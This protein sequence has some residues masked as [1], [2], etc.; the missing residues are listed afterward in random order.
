M[1]SAKLPLNGEALAYAAKDYIDTAYEQ[2]RDVLEWRHLPRGMM[3]IWE[4]SPMMAA[5]R[6]N[7]PV[8]IAQFPDMS[9]V[10]VTFPGSTAVNRMRE[11]LIAGELI[12]KTDNQQERAHE[13]ATELFTLCMRY[14]R[15]QNLA[16]HI[17]TAVNSHLRILNIETSRERSSLNRSEKPLLSSTDSASLERIHFLLSTRLEDEQ[18]VDDWAE[19]V[20]EL[21]A[22]QSLDAGSSDSRV[23]DYESK[24]ESQVKSELRKRGVVA[25][26]ALTSYKLRF[27]QA[28][29]ATL[30]LDIVQKNTRTDRT[31][32]KS[33]A[34]LLLELE[35]MPDDMR[36]LY[37]LLEE[38]R[39][40]RISRP[41][42]NINGVRY[43]M[44]MYGNDNSKK[45]TAKHVLSLDGREFVIEGSRG[46][47]TAE[48]ISGV[49]K[50]IS[51]QLSID[52]DA[53]E[54]AAAFESGGQ[55]LSVRIERPKTSDQKK[56][57]A[58][59]AQLI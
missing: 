40:K 27:K 35:E 58:V 36:E 10:I 49:M 47:F 15:V 39:P 8:P 28:L 11:I 5:E 21:L 14:T 2:V 18:E 31:S 29:A 43:E 9:Q 30:D 1:S 34:E 13:I 59:L 19:D 51:M 54:L 7:H 33:I 25:P 23:S 56:I 55:V 4:N 32:N 45:T 57:A 44:K 16:R 38:L 41:D 37:K 3:A 50:T 6:K 20:N 17:R 12:A 42:A 52:P 46:A 53:R 24:V 26:G 48:M 22:R